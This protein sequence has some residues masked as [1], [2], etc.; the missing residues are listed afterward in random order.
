MRKIAL[1]IILFAVIIQGR[2][3]GQPAKSARTERISSAAGPARLTPRELTSR[4]EIVAVGTITG[5][6]SAWSN[7][8]SRITTRATLRVDELLEGTT[9]GGSITLVYPGGEVGG[10]GEKYTH[11]ASFARNEE[12]VVFARRL[13]DDCRIV[14]GEEGKVSIHK[15]SITGKKMVSGVMSLDQFKSDVSA[16]GR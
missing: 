10:E 5:I 15:N 4:A 13:G 6:Q 3:W 2:G 14:G 7:D 9:S 1:G 12:V 8:R 16:A 11:I